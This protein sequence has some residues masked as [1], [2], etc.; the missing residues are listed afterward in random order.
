METLVLNLGKQFEDDVAYEF[1]VDE[2]YLLR[3]PE[4]DVIQQSENIIFRLRNM[5]SLKSFPVYTYNGSFTMHSIDWFQKQKTTIVRSSYDISNIMDIHDSIKGKFQCVVEVIGA[6]LSS[7]T[8]AAYRMEQTARLITN[9]AGIVGE[10]N[11]IPV[12]NEDLTNLVNSM[13]KSI[14]KQRFMYVHRFTRDSSDTSTNTIKSKTFDY[15]I[16]DAKQKMDDYQ[17]GTTYQLLLKLK[18]VEEKQCTYLRTKLYR[19]HAKMVSIQELICLNKDPSEASTSENNNVNEENH[20]V[21]ETTTT[22]TTTSSSPTFKI[23]TYNLWNYNNPWKQ[24]RNMIVDNIVKQDPELIA[25]QEA[26][27]CQWEGETDYM[28]NPR[29]MGQER[30]QIQ[31]LVNLLSFQ[32]KKYHYTF[33]PSMVYLNGQQMQ[34]EGLA[35]LS[36]YPIKD[37]SSIKLSRDFNDNEDVH[38]RS[39]LRVL[40]DTPNGPL[41]LLTSHFSLSLSG[42]VR[43]AFEVTNYTK[44]FESPQIFVG[45]LNSVPDS[46]AIQ[47]LVGKVVEN[48]QTGDFQDSFTDWTSTN[49]P[50]DFVGTYSTLGGTPNKRIDYIMKRGAEL[51]LVDFKQLGS[52]PQ[53]AD[54]DPNRE[55]YA[56][57]HLSLVATYKW[58]SKT[59]SK[60]TTVVVPTPEIK[61]NTG[62]VETA[63]KEDHNMVPPIAPIP[64]T[65]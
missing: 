33:I 39:C 30:N 3:V 52:E 2:F 1:I 31:H 28:P 55:V 23:L 22:S 35:I 36:K 57:D 32:N 40:V 20:Q 64:L 7:N 37:T 45:D 14:S 38:Q 12:D 10:F 6:D 34:Y 29:M 58:L 42:A 26:R 41:N 19:D 65:K 15:T 44:Q 46:H 51:E 54:D 60:T 59:E 61:T 43:N 8:N 4:E 63:L 62:V 27:Y 24:R 13:K 11:E 53:P 47:F 9:K 56:S 49:R 16:L 48:N 50:V 18:D 25:F 5:D 21:G 17:I